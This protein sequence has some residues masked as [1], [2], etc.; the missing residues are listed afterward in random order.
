[1][2]RLEY[3]CFH[4]NP[5]CEWLWAWGPPMTKNG[6]TPAIDRIAVPQRSDPCL[7]SH[8]SGMLSRPPPGHRM[9]FDQLG[10]R[11]FITLLGSTAAWPLAARAQQP[12][13][14]VIGFLNGAS[15][16]EWTP[17]LTAFRSGLRD[18]GFIEG[19][20]VAI[21]FRWAEGRYDP[22]GGLRPRSRFFPRAFLTDQRAF[23]AG[24]VQSLRNAGGSRADIYCTGNC[25]CELCRHRPHGGL[26]SFCVQPSNG[27]IGVRPRVSG[28]SCEGGHARPAPYEVACVFHV[29]A[30]LLP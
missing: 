12:A 3:A 30:S 29:C 16:A 22:P 25:Q 13:M 2:T 7:D 18:S 21:E 20:N 24:W 27:G 11:E 10:R 23:S 4:V 17:F 14:P 9:Q 5:D 8:R 6:P 15:P 1:M 28:E 19:Q 26:R